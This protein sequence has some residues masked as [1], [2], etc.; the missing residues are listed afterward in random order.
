MALPRIPIS[1]STP[2]PVSPAKCLIGLADWQWV[3][4]GATS[5]LTVGGLD[6]SGARPHIDVSPG[7]CR[8]LAQGCPDVFP[9]Q[10]LSGTSQG[11]SF[12]AMS[13]QEHR[14]KTPMRNL[15][16]LDDYS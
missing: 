14:Q 9:W 5:H 1:P 10:E 12:G 7:P 6:T 11:G 15:T 8:I 16:L 4:V 13:C 2:G 3:P